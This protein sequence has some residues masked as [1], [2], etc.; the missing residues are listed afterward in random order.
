M[1]KPETIAQLRRK[2]ERLEARITVLQS[3]VDGHWD[4]YRKNLFDVSDAQIR[5]KQA[6]RI[7]SGEDE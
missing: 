7:L 2:I 5:I 3:V 6:M 1:T 4:V